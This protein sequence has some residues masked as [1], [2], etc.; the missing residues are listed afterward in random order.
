MDD[1]T[2]AERARLKTA[3]Q[4]LDEEL[5]AWLVSFHRCAKTVNCDEVRK[6]LRDTSD[7]HELT[8][9]LR[10]SRRMQERIR[11]TANFIRDLTILVG[12][13]TAFLFWFLPSIGFKLL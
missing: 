9:N 7:L 10:A 6:L 13:I 5:I 3:L 4:H 12:G 8:V 2:E 1:L 11:S